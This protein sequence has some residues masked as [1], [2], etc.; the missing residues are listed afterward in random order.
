MK[1]SSPGAAVKRTKFKNPPIHELSIALFHLPIVEMKA[2]HIGTYWDRIRRKYPLCEQQP[3]IPIVSLSDAQ[4]QPPTFFQEVPGEV[5]PLPRF[6]FSNMLHPTLIQVQRNAFILNWRRVTGSEEYPHYE[7]VMEQFWQEL[8]GYRTFVKES[9]GG[10]LDVIQRCELTYI[11]LIGRNE[12]FASPAD[13]MNVIPP[14]ASLYDIQ[15][16][17]RKL[18]GLNATITY[19]LNPTLLVDLAIRLGNRLDTKELVAMLEL[20]AHGVPSDL[21][22]DGARAWYDS[23]HEATYKLFLDATDKKVQKTIWKPR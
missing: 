17:D 8:T 20:K 3:P 23:A 19:G 12:T 11:N 5:F 16:D 6:W 18:A 13:L 21:S 4:A 9:V 7:T 10:R 2:Q 15:T 1:K 22:L 14:T